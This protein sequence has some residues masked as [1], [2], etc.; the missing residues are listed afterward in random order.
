MGGIL[1]QC[2]KW[3]DTDKCMANS[4]TDQ[5]YSSLERK[6]QSMEQRMGQMEE[7][8]NTTDE[9]N[10]RLY[11]KWKGVDER[12]QQHETQQCAHHHMVMTRLRSVEQRMETISLDHCERLDD[13]I[14]IVEER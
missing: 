13:D 11:N 2:S 10:Q 8:I 12:L 6:L 4:W 3:F 5:N 14:V 9:A 1:T 7:R